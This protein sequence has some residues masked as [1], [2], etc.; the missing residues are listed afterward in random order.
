MNSNLIKSVIKIALF[1]SLVSVTYA[2]DNVTI[3]LNYYGI[4]S[5][6]SDPNGEYYYAYL[7]AYVETGYV[8]WWDNIEISGYNGFEGNVSFEILAAYPGGHNEGWFRVKIWSDTAGDNVIKITANG[9]YNSTYQE[10]N[11]VVNEVYYVTES[12]YPPEVE[13]GTNVTFTAISYPSCSLIETQ[14]Y[15]RYKEN[16]ESAWSDWISTFWNPFYATFTP[17]SET[18]GNPLFATFSTPGIYQLIVRNGDY[19]TYKYSSE[20]TVGVIVD[21]DVAY[22]TNLDGA[23]GTS[24]D[25]STEKEPGGLVVKKNDDSKRLQICIWKA[26]PS[27]WSGNLVLT[28]TNVDK[29]KIYDASTGGTEIIQ[30]TNNTFPN[31]SISS[32]KLLFVEGINPSDHMRDVKLTLTA[33]GVT[34]SVF[35]EVQLT[36]LWVTLTAKFSDSEELSDDNDKRLHIKDDYII[37]PSDYKLGKHF[38]F[39][40]LETGGAGHWS[41]TVEFKGDVEPNDFVPSQ[42]LKVTDS[43]HP[44]Y[45]ERFRGANNFYKGPNG[46]ENPPETLDTGIESSPFDLRD[47]NPAPAGNIY[48]WDLPGISVLTDLPQ[49]SIRRFRTNFTSWA[50]VVFGTGNVQRCSNK[51]VWHVA[52]SIKK[53]DQEQTG[54]A[55]SGSTANT[56][57]KSGNWT[58]PTGHPWLFV[59]ITSGKGAPQIRAIT[60]ITDDTLTIKPNWKNEDNIPDDTSHYR[61]ISDL[62]WVEETTYNDNEDPQKRDN[63][64]GEGTCNITYN[65]E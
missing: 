58:Y 13:P 64:T 46:N 60:N 9:S 12:A 37:S 32:C 39:T 65:M 47:D 41:N 8:N 35:D 20:V 3:S 62:T 18:Y 26:K 40:R 50:K 43:S 15:A 34:P 49:N 28:W 14:W 30:G 10:C 31:S 5:P 52:R 29:I 45:L 1:L 33:Q 36:V 4:V 57:K 16:S 24:S 27:T 42:F 19:D 48:D 11:F 44:F 25:D 23:T 59:Q 63:Q 2:C 38:V 53:T 61:V 51:I 55:S 6:K 7:D 56:L 22:D 21:L 54:T 17:Q